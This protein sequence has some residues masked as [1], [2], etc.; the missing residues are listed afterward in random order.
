MVLFPRRQGMGT[1]LMGGSNAPGRASAALP[2]YAESR[3]H[4]SGRRLQSRPPP[5]GGRVGEA[6]VR[7]HDPACCIDSRG[8]P[9][10]GMSAVA[11]GEGGFPWAACFKLPVVTSPLRDVVAILSFKPAANP[12]PIADTAS[13]CAHAPPAPPETGIFAGL[14]RGGVRER[15]V[16]TGHHDPRPPKAFPPS[17][18]AVPTSPSRDGLLPAPRPPLKRGRLNK[19]IPSCR[20]VPQGE[21]FFATQKT[22]R[23]AG[24]GKQNARPV[25]RPPG[26]DAAKKGRK[27]DRVFR[28]ARVSAYS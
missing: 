16:P 13:A 9:T 17:A 22:T 25:L 5:P 24:Q 23:P 8:T 11:F 3:L 14:Q 2:L 7:P 19:D 10:P 4:A 21:C 20:T 15:V 12:S 1:G 28:R 6:V 18:M 26:V 27:S